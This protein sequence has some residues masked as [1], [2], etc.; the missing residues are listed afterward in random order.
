MLQTPPRPALDLHAAGALTSRNPAA[1]VN[2]EAPGGPRGRLSAACLQAVLESALTPPPAP[3]APFRRFQTRSAVLSVAY[4][5][6][7]FSPIGEKREGLHEIGRIQR[8]LQSDAATG[9]VAHHVSAR[10]TQ[11]L[12]QQA[13]VAGLVCDAQRRGCSRTA[14]E[15]DAMIANEPMPHT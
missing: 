11:V 5:A 3:T 2:H 12:L 9:G 13:G 8:E 14:R 4:A 10:D 15:A 1:R 6:I 7:G